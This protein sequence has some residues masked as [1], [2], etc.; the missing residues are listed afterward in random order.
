MHLNG[1]LFIAASSL[2]VLSLFLWCRL[3]ETYDERNAAHG[4]LRTIVHRYQ[5]ACDTIERMKLQIGELSAQVDMG[6]YGDRLRR[7]AEQAFRNK[8][9]IGD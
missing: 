2:A 3:L 6:D 1:Y 8:H 5:D 4:A 9:G 7:E